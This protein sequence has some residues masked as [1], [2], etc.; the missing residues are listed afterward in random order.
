MRYVLVSSQRVPQFFRMSSDPSA[1]VSLFHGAFRRGYI[2]QSNAQSGCWYTF[3][4]LNPDLLTSDFQHLTESGVRSFQNPI[5]NNHTPSHFYCCCG[6][7]FFLIFTLPSPP[8]LGHFLYPVLP[9]VFLRRTLTVC[10]IRAIIYISYTR[11]K[12]IPCFCFYILRYAYLFK[13]CFIINPRGIGTH[14]QSYQ[15]SNQD[16]KTFDCSFR[17]SGYHIYIVLRVV[18]HAIY[19][20]SSF[21]HVFGP[22]MPSASSPFAD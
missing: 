12:R 3:S 2:R 16:P 8:Q 22:Q 20:P 17:Q 1:D 4:H 13:S 15:Q 9:P 6:D 14:Q 18:L 5:A 19:T 11:N 10:L 7:Y 21:A